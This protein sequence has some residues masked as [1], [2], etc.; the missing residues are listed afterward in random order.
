[1]RLWIIY[2]QALRGLLSFRIFTHIFLLAHSA[3]LPILRYSCVWRERDGK[4]AS[5]KEEVEYNK[6][7]F[8]RHG[9]TRTKS[10]CVADKWKKHNSH[11]HHKRGIKI[12]EKRKRLQA[13]M[14]MMAHSRQISNIHEINRNKI[15]KFALKTRTERKG[16]VITS[17]TWCASNCLNNLFFYFY[18]TSLWWRSFV[19]SRVPNRLN[20]NIKQPWSVNQLQQQ[21]RLLLMTQNVTHSLTYS[22]NFIFN[23]NERTYRILAAD[24]LCNIVWLYWCCN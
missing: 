24:E 2:S 20:L 23:V 4:Q 17:L 18:T 3:K 13:I 21:L 10:W 12:K 11:R 8:F 5:R 1:M 19:S 22:K 16:K 9:H 7:S 15:S 14:M 6:T